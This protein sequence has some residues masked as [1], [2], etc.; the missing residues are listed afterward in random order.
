MSTPSYD[1]HGKAS[2]L[3]TDDDSSPT[4]ARDLRQVSIAGLVQ[5]ILVPADL[6][7]GGARVQVY[8]DGMK[9]GDEVT[10]R[11]QTMLIAANLELTLTVEADGRPLAFTIPEAVLE[12][13]LE[14]DATA[15]Y[16][17]VRGPYL[18]RS[19]EREVLIR[20]ILVVPLTICEVLDK[21]GPVANGGTTTSDY[22]VL[23]GTAMPDREVEVFR[24]SDSLKVVTVKENGS[25]L[26]P[27]ERGAGSSTFTATAR[28]AGD[29][30]SNAWTITGGSVGPGGEQ[31]DIEEEIV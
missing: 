14:L 30:V 23:Y 15:A 21:Q 19:L 17:V 1:Q 27:V 28:Y 4:Q 11:W 26:W 18:Y 22:V 13:G 25:W 5:N 10:L 12:V 20:S 6:P 9:A 31:G 16:S 7:A 24:G 29:L 2:A 3:N 8:Y